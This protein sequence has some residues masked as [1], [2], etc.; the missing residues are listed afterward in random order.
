MEN[1]AGNKILRNLALLA[2][3]LQLSVPGAYAQQDAK[4]G[5]DSSYHNY[6]YDS[7]TAYF[8][9][10]P[11]VKKPTVFFGDSI[12]HWGD[13][14]EFTGFSKVLNR[15]I[16]GDNS[17]GLLGRLDEVTRHRPDKLFVLI[18]TNDLNLNSNAAIQHV[19]NNYRRLVYNV[20]RSSPS[21][22]IYIQSVFPI[23]DQ[24][25]NT[26]YYKGTNAQ[27]R[28]MNLRLKSLAQELSIRYVDVYSSLL[29]K[30]S[31]LDARFTYDGL[32]LSG[33]GYLA[34]VNYLRKER[35]L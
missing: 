23:N 8:R 34:W 7:R 12:T 32:H 14:A 3:S 18:G 31:Q 9:Q 28:E 19:V 29:D 24:L 22:T 10:L 5:Y 1:L 35:L 16:S 13:W 21:T 6:L 33:E 17:F 20:R 2:I 15:G 30:S 11:I 27:V 25:I 4:M 26:K